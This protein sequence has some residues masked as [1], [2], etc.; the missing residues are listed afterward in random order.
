MPEIKSGKFSIDLGVFKI[1]TEVSE[2]DRQCAWEM[3]TEMATRVAVTGKTRD[4][5]CKDFSGEVLIESL[6]SLH[7]FLMELRGIMKR[8]PVGRLSRDKKHHL[9]VLI[10]D[11]IVNVLRPFLE[12]WQ[13]EY[14]FWWDQ[15]A[16]AKVSPMQRQEEYSKIEEFKKDWTD[17]RLVL[18]QV[19][20]KL[21]VAYQLVD[22]NQ[23]GRLLGV[24]HR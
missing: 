13:A 8:F 24:G 12:H 19:M 1:E 17:L 15:E 3:Y 22:T 18:R 2:E 23:V 14:R 5:E 21:V 10:N 4:P 9:G 16:N 11:A 20:G 6:A 7:Q